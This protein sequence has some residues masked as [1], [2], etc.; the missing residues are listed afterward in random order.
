M[1]EQESLVQDYLSRPA[2]YANIDGFNELTWGA[3]LCWFASLDWIHTMVPQHSLWHRPW[4]QG[5]YMVAGV[6][7]IHFGGKAFK[8]YVTYPRT[9]FVAYPETPARRM[10]PFVAFAVAIP[11]TFLAAAVL[12]RGLHLATLLGATNSVFYAFAAQPLRPWKF[13]FLLLIASGALWISDAYALPF[14]GLAFLASGATT[15][16]LYLLRTRS[17]Q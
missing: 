15:L 17:A 9:G 10:V 16:T 6:L 13:G 11:T 8:R 4:A 2:R 14:F 7:A 3:I 5:L 12:R 1:K